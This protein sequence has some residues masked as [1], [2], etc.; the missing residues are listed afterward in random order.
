LALFLPLFV[1][2]ALIER[3]A[4]RVLA[5]S[6]VAVSVIALLMTASR[7]AFVGLVGASA[8]I[9]V[10][11]R[12]CVTRKGH[13]VRVAAFLALVISGVTIM[14]FGGYGDLL[15]NRFIWDSTGGDATKISS[16]RIF[17]WATAIE[18]MLTQPVTLI[19]GFGWDAYFQFR[20]FRFA[21]HNVYL[22]IF[23]ELGAI[24]LILMLVALFNILRIARGSLR[25]AEGESSIIILGFIFGLISILI[26][27]FFVDISTPW[28]FIWAYVGTVM[29][30]ALLQ[31]DTSYST[32]VREGHS[33]SFYNYPG[34]A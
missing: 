34:P 22:K 28:I 20:V 9:A 33:S 32:R 3:G 8:I 11:L 1:A 14:Y 7:G 5:L 18:K 4:L 23:F 19:T 12:K 17:I 2:L 31:S 6:G 29:R 27:M 15:Y 30:L 25:W 16:G 13:G 24:G 10:M 26:A 21:P